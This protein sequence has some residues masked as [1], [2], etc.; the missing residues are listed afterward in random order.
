M[1]IRLFKAGHGDCLLVESEDESTRILVDGGWPTAYDEHIARSLGFLRSRDQAIDLLYVSHI[2]RDHIGGV[3]RMLEAA[4]D[5]RIFRFQ[6]SQGNTAF[7]EPRVPEPAEIR[8][9]WHNAFFDDPQ[10]NT[11]AIVNALSTNASLLS[12]A[13][14]ADARRLAAASEF[15]GESVGDAL[16]VSRRIAASQLG[17]PLNP[18]FGGRFVL[19]SA[20]APRLQVGA[21]ALDV[22]GPTR[23]DLREL[24]REWNEWLRDH[25][26]EIA[27]IERA[28]RRDED[29]L[30]GSSLGDFLGS[31]EASAFDLAS[32]RVTP[33][34]LA[35]IVVLV[36]ENGQRAL[37]TGDAD[38]PQILAGLEARGL[39]DADGN[40]HVNLLKVPHHGA[41]NSFSEEFVR[42]VIAD[43][44]V[45]CGDGENDNPEKDVVAGYIDSRIGPQAKRS[46]HAAVG[47]RFKLW[48]NYDENSA[49]P[50][51]RRH[52][53]DLEAMVRRRA[54]R[55]SGL[56]FRFLGNQHSISI[57]P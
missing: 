1:R 56:H 50:K 20:G 52:F 36:E 24:I 51:H 43:H 14:G 38:D 41:H 55:G 12:A 22:L 17:I 15:L 16:H 39:T 31:L 13:A 47:R 54:R 10:L 32:Q 57:R 33:P 9:I 30:V 28:H 37:L 46:T 3:K 45:F 42:R 11:P 35:S 8:A 6:R 18:E 2:D 29:R 49:E 26:G 21:F 44:Y 40:I 27:R 19:R 48:F 53:A 4:V 7:R 25:E 23:Q 5:W 34:N